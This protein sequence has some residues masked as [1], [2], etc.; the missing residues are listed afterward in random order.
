MRVSGSDLK[1]VRYARIPPDTGY[2]ILENLASKPWT[3]LNM[4]LK[5][6][7]SLANTLTIETNMHILVLQ[8][9]G[10]LPVNAHA[11]VNILNLNYI[12]AL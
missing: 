12:T 8:C 7:H 6:S 10:M 3:H 11:E 5:Y 4:Q 1:W 9:S 2:R